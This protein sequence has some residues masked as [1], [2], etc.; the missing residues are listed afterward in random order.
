MVAAP[1][2]VFVVDDDADTTECM[3]L[4]LKHYGHDVRIANRG[5]A[6]IEQVPV[7][8]PDLVLVDLAMPRVDGLTV[9]RQL[10]L[11]PELADISLVAV[12]GYADLAHRQQALDAGFDE[13]VAKP[14]PL[15]QLLQLLARVRG[16]IDASRQRA[17][18]AA[19]AAAAARRL[20]KDS[21]RE[22]ARVSDRPIDGG[23]PAA[24]LHIR[25]SGIS[26]VISLDDENVA[27]QIR[28]WLRD[29]GCRVGPVFYQSPGRC[30]FFAYSRRQ[31]RA[32]LAAHPQFEIKDG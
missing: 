22:L 13:C 3:S 8:R 16:R 24:V 17:A 4:L 23:L 28:Q 15:D 7:F 10:R 19:E 21:R 11:R 26:E 30:A 18:Q 12:T 31:M 6:A 5:E 2:R 9:A 20:A 32:L 27:V 29:C 14:L 1:M 25:K